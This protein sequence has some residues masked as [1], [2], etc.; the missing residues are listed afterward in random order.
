MRKMKLATKLLV[1]FLAVGVIPSAVIGL[2]ALQKAGN[3]LE[4]SAYGQLVAMREIKEKQVNNYFSERQGDMGV[5]CENVKATNTNAWENL[6]GIQ[7]TKREQ[8]KNL[9]ANMT[10]QLETVSK[11]YATK[12]AFADFKT[13]HDTSG[14]KSDGE[15]DVKS[16]EYKAIYDKW[17][18][19]FAVYVKEFG[20]Y[21]IFIIC[22]KHGHVLFTE[23]KESDLG[24]NVNTGPLQNEGLGKVW[25]SV[26]DSRKT[27]FADFAPYSP[28]DGDYASFIGTPILDDT[29][30]VMAVLALQ[31]PTKPINA[32]VQTRTGMG[33]TGETYLVG[34]L[35][36]R[37]S[38]RSNM[39]TMGDGKYIVGAEIKTTY[40]EKAIAGKSA[41]E[42][43][44]D[45]SGNPVM[46][47]Y[48]PLN[49]EGLNW[50]QVTKM[51]LAECFSLKAEG[52]NE[53]YLTKYNNMYGY[54][55][56]FLLNPDGY[57]F[58]TVCHEADYQTNLVNGKY[59][60]SAL[61]KAVRECLDTK[62][63]SFGDFSPYAPSKNAPCGFI[64]QPVI[65]NGKVELIVALQLSDAAINEMITAG[66]NKEKTLE[67][68]LVGADGY[69][70]SSSIL[71]PDSYSIAASFA[72][73]NKVSTDATKGALSGGTDAKVIKDY[74]GSDVLSAW[75]PLN[76]FGTKW[77]LICEIDE[78]VAFEARTA[79]IWLMTI[80]SIIAIVAI[81][82]L[83][84]IITRS[85]TKPINR[86]INELN[87]GAEQVSSASGQVSAAS[88]SLA[89]G[90]TEQAAGLEETSSSLE[91]MSS[92]TKTNAQNATQANTLS[93]EARGAADT[94]NQAMEQMSKAINEIQKSSEETAKIIKVIDE[95]AF[96]TNLL[97][98]N[99]AVEAA[100]AGE[101]GK[102]FAVVAEE[103]RN[104]AMRSAEAA[105]NTSEMIEASVKNAQ[106]G[107]EISGEVAKSLDKIVGGISKAADLVGEIAAASQEQSQGIN[108]INTAMTQMDKVTQQNAANAEESASASEELNAQ[109]EQMKGA[110][111]ELVTLVG[112][113]SS[114]TQSTGHP[115]V[116]N[117]MSGNLS[118][119]DHAFH[120]I[121]GAKKTPAKEAIPMG[122]D[123]GG[124]FDEFND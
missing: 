68:Y 101:A 113:N 100:R 70:R 28:S 12:A 85:I 57:C 78:A 56:L 73:G 52:D 86:I 63:F 92:M 29:G 2:L 58:Y 13:Y 108:Q 26:V 34:E 79:I 66:A 62:K 60:D 36:G 25:R 8:V 93:V 90:S 59:A 27:S 65:N 67:G 39:L 45:S 94:G 22:G 110:V 20:Y 9:I 24:A 87:V 69:M 97:A 72:N 95:I 88:Q 83:A 4:E 64:A 120:G 32:I 21:D 102:G 11:S 61:G 81:V 5:L 23:C 117:K 31:M 76:V 7:Q 53:D 114:Q 109:A 82:L 118:H 16:A 80:V 77:A 119:S 40:I 98:L 1:A 37:T 49:I 6:I 38:F 42:V 84:V 115:S 43:Q 99:A 104:L 112:G 75:A 48:D 14:A 89:E 51:D 30:N 91:E 123:N 15:L 74:L 121:A 3:A 50:A 10:T 44:Y 124:D 19:E 122:A 47:C 107:V 46:V 71:N 103:V 41:Q 17:Y 111:N 55:D 18:D 35:N 96:Q 105:K 54:Y 106:N 116:T 33:K